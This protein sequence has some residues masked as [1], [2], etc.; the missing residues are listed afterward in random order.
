MPFAFLV[1]YLSAFVLEAQELRSASDEATLS[2]DASRAIRGLIFVSLF[3]AYERTVA[4]CV[5]TA[6]AQA[7]AYAIPHRQLKAGLLPLA[8]HS[9]ATSVRGVSEAK[10][11]DRCREFF[12]KARSSEPAV[13]PDLFP[14]DGSFMRPTQLQ[15]I[16]RVFDL[17]GDPWPDPRMIGRITELVD[18]RN[19]IAHGSEPPSAVGGRYSTGDLDQRIRD[20]EVLCSHIISVFQAECS[21][22]VGFE[23]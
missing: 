14:K 21:R 17:P 4:G 9:D 7:N 16:W 20:V 3:G 18:A 22:P 15:L 1:G 6:V 23:V 10:F 19:E 5:S 13:L 8:L 2:A 11:W 12:A